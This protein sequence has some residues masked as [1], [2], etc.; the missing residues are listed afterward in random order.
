MVLAFI[1]DLKIDVVAGNMF[2]TELLCN[3]DNKD[4]IKKK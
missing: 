2:T 3:F 1:V 4:R